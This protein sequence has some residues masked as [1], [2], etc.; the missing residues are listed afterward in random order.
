MNVQPFI[1]NEKANE[2]VAFV[3]DIFH[4]QQV[5][6]SSEVDQNPLVRTI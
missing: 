2:Q 5:V 4:N 3:D 1:W 6:D